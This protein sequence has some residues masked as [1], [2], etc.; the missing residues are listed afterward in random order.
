MKSAYTHY[1]KEA[2]VRDGVKYQHVVGLDEV[3]DWRLILDLSADPSW[4]LVTMRRP[5]VCRFPGERKKRVP[6]RARMHCPECGTRLYDCEDRWGAGMMDVLALPPRPSSFELWHD[7]ECACP[8][9]GARIGLARK[10]PALPE[11]K[12]GWWA[13]LRAGVNKR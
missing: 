6:R 11:G 5:A 4:Q 1:F 3:W 9:C 13:R 8:A 10:R 7:D 12:I 2:V